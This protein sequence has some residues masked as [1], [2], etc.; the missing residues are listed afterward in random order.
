MNV[1]KKKSQ[2]WWSEHRKIGIVECRK[3]RFEFNCIHA[4]RDLSRLRL[5]KSDYHPLEALNWEFHVGV[6]K[7]EIFLGQLGKSKPSTIEFLKSNLNH[8]K[9][10]QPKL[11][12]FSRVLTI[13][14]SPASHPKKKIKTKLLSYPRWKFYFW[15]SWVL[16]KLLFFGLQKT[17]ITGPC[18]HTGS[19]YPCC[20]VMGASLDFGA[21]KTPVA[22]IE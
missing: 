13:T 4:M 15:T 19:W 14:R 3:V 21:Q 12:A 10:Q 17:R 9:I 5:L 2:V 22:S 18:I 16:F 8:P 11:L 20:K 7:S 1:P 6:I